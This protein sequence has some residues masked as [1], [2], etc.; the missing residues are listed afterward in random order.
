MGLV[1]VEF[2]SGGDGSD[3]EWRTV[4]P[5]TRSRA[6]TISV[7][8]GDIASPA[9][10]IALCSDL[11]YLAP[12][13]TL[14]LGEGPRSPSPAVIWALGR[15]GRRAL[16]RGLLSAADIGATEAV[17]IG[18]AHKVVD[19]PVELP[20]SLTCSLTAVTTA[21]DL[22]RS[23]P[24]GSAGLALELAAFRLLFAAGDPEEGAMA[25]LEKREPVF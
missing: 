12:S 13:V 4:E 20:I 11:V 2:G 22:M 3:L 9:L 17:E 1:V 15:A 7:L 6:V 14:R 23:A 21:R 10:D 18:I 5:W 25:F 8:G 16:A 19:D 24:S